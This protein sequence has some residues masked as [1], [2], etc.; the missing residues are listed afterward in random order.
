M[1]S[2]WL[3][4]FDM[5]HYI[6]NIFKS[7]IGSPCSR[8]VELMEKTCQYLLRGHSTGHSCELLFVAVSILL[9]RSS[10]IFPW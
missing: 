4:T 7:G 6:G 1:S 2:T 9:L 8:K 10:S 3:T 5:F